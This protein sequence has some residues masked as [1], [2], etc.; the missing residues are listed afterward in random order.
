[1][2]RMTAINAAEI[3]CVGTELLLGQIVNTNAAW[4]AREL[5]LLGINSYYQ[6]VVGDN[7][8]RLQAVLQ[9][10]AD[11]SDLIILT[12]G[13]GPTQDDLTMAG[14]ARFAGL[15]LHLHEPS[16]AAIQDYFH[17]IGR[18]EVTA[19]NWKQAL[20][21][22]GAIVLP[23]HNGTAPGAI[24]ETV[25]AGR[26]VRLIL[27]PGPPSEMQLM[28]R[29]SVAPYLESQSANRLR[30]LFVRLIGIGESAAETRLLDLIENQ[31]NP[32]LAPYASEGEVLFRITQSVSQPDEPDRTQDLL[33]EVRR[34]L[35]EYIY[36]VGPRSMPEVLKDLLT[37][38]NQTIGFAE[39]CTGGMVSAAIT[40][41]PGSSAVFRGSVVAYDNAVKM[42]ILH[43]PSDIIN[44][45]GAVSESCAIA[46][47]T[48]CRDILNTD[49]AVAVTGIAGPDGGSP[50]KPVGLVWLAVAS[51]AG[52][53]TRRLQLGGNRARIRKVATLN[54]L[55]L[56]RRCLLS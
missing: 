9:L 40:D 47:A 32:T 8:D 2:N 17:S 43:V 10:A 4:L 45:A 34:R 27:L 31:R 26:P 13:L 39:S 30:H 12:G 19:N 29:E 44:Q 33:A 23:N 25:R 36:E 1:M 21:P 37:E 49:L 38:R 52:T 53:Q 14:A 24:L 3:L 11:R 20:L 42:A 18:R 51:A 41:L 50:A 16:R 46:M 54:A 55:D 48:G 35:G 22:D 28:F 56:A 5:S 6:T 15:Q 7:A